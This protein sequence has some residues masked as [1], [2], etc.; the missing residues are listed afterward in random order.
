MLP[1]MLALA[2]PAS[3]GSSA[4]APAAP[5][6]PAEARLAQVA[7][8]VDLSAGQT[9]YAQ[10]AERQFLPASMTKAMSALVAFDLIKAGKLDEDAVVTVRPE[11]AQRWA[12]KGT[13]LSLVP[14]QEWLPDEM[15]TWSRHSSRAEFADTAGERSVL[16]LRILSIIVP[17]NIPA[18]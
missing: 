14:A 18:T 15:H 16:L 11:T 13:T 12:G 4:L 5:V 8:V 6:P 17:I 3:A 2:L 7:R 9:L 1:L 10:E